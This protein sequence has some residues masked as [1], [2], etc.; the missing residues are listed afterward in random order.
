M[1]LY[2]LGW[3]LNDP[4]RPLLEAVAA[5]VDRYHARFGYYP[6]LVQV[7]AAL[8]EVLGETVNVNGA[9]LRVVVGAQPPKHMLF[10]CEKP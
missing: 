6:T 5:G 9:R 2:G 7:G 3:C 10:C 4:K 1:I 8:A